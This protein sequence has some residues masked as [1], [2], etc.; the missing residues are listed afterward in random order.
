MEVLV[1]LE[2]LVQTVQVQQ[3]VHQVVLHQ[4]VLQVVLQVLHQVVLQVLHQVVH[5]DQ[6]KFQVVHPD[7][8]QEVHQGH[9]VVMIPVLWLLVVIASQQLAKI[10]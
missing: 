2:V 5:Q 1:Y 9:A 10:K 3:V 4:V 7:P 6:D 8:D